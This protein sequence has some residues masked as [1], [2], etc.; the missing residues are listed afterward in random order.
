M[1]AYGAIRVHVR[2]DVKGVQLAQAHLVGVRARV[3]GRV[4]GRARDGVRV[5]A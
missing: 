1:A 2:Y 5:R 3:R 4:R